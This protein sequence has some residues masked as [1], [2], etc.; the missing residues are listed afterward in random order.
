MQKFLINIKKVIGKICG[1]FDSIYFPISF[2]AIELLCYYL[3]LDI[4]IIAIVSLSL[5]FVFL[6]KKELNC[7][8]I[9]FLFMSSMI[10]LKNSPASL[11]IPN[12]NP[13]YYFQPGIYITCIIFVVLP[14]LIVIVKAIKNLK[15]KKIEFDGFFYSCLIFGAALLFNGLFTS[16]YTLLDSMFGLFMFF[17]FVILL[18]AILPQVSINEKTL[19]KL[20]KQVLI[21][22]AVPLIELIVFYICYLASGDLTE[23]RLDIALGWGNRNTLGMLF[24]VLFPF[25]LYLAKR[26]ENK[27][28]KMFSHCFGIVVLLAIVFTFSRQ[29]YLFIFCLITGF[30]IHQYCGA[31]ATEKNKNLIVLCCWGGVLFILGFVAFFGGF[32]KS[33]G[34]GSIDARYLLWIDSINSVNKNPIL[35]SGFFFIGY[36]PV[37]QLNSVM[38]YCCHNTLFEMLGACGLFG[39]GAYIVYRILSVRKIIKDI[40]VERMYPFLACGLIVLM[41]L[42]DIHLFDFFG[43][44]IYVILL[45]MSLPKASTRNQINELSTAGS[46]KSE[47]TAD[48]KVLDECLSGNENE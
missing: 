39:F 40:T 10:S 26:G 45:A 18:F 46:G 31:K 19:N 12:C 48:K 9:L 21:Y 27:K 11:Y 38:P 3:G 15:D 1:F 17:F 20:S 35:G 25:I 43:S 41:S 37:V 22:L 7:V 2:C 36:D 8:L 42:I 30:L 44:G 34:A 5:S 23:E 32:L 6:F 14:A 13:G 24:V 4:A 16:D 47:N 28:I 33:F 29:S